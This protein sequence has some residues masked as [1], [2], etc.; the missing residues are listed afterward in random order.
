MPDDW[1]CLIMLLILI[2]I[3]ISISKSIILMNIAVVAW[4]HGGGLASGLAGMYEPHFIMDY[5][6][7]AKN[8]KY[9]LSIP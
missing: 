4:F 1:L 5:Q 2:S 9:I 7:E 6:V 8:T 3:S